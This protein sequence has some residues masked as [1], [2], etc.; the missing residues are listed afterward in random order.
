MTN[1]NEFITKF[2]E[3]P[4]MAIHLARLAWERRQ[5]L[6]AHLVANHCPSHHNIGNLMAK[7]ISETD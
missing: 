3:A 2:A 6:D 5:E 4:P 1:W 7:E